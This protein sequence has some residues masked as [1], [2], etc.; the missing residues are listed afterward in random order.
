[1]AKP[2]KGASPKIIKTTAKDLQAAIKEAAGAKLRAK[3]A[4][5][6]KSTGLTDYRTKSGFSGRALSLGLELHAMDDI[7][8]TD[9]V[10]ELL[11]IHQMMGWGEQSDLFDDIG[12]QIT[13]AAKRAEDAEAKRQGKPT[14][15]ESLPLEALAKGIKPLAEDAT[16]ASRRARAAK[17][18]HDGPPGEAMKAGAAE[19]D[20]FLR[21][22]V[23]KRSGRTATALPDAPEMLESTGA[24]A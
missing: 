19:G 24:S 3:N 18:V 5:V 6:S 4:S 16:A 2:K 17:A 9:L 10:R 23:A 20:A 22:Q 14:G 8:R 1:M 7:K 21:E 13:E 12:A 11:M 15:T